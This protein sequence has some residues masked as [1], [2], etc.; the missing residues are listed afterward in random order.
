MAARE[1]IKFEEEKLSI[2]DIITIKDLEKKVFFVFN[3][4]INDRN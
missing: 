3:E 2:N 4:N 1:Q